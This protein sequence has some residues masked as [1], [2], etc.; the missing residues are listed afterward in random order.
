MWSCGWRHVKVG[1]DY[2]LT[3]SKSTAVRLL[4]SQPQVQVLSEVEMVHKHFLTNAVN[5]SRLQVVGPFH[6]V[7]W[8]L[9][10]LSQA[11]W[12]AR[13]HSVDIEL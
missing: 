7:I 4:A 9:M 12:C 10:F 5:F 3:A 13:C 1:I 6:F 2:R 11:P 8:I